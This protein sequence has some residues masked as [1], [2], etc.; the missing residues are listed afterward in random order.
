MAEALP[1][2]ARAMPDVRL[3]G[4]GR[5]RPYSNGILGPETMPITFG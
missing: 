3:D 2:L 4:P 1:L 5:W